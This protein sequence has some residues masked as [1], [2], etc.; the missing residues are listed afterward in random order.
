MIKIH[1]VKPKNF[2]PG[3]HVSICSLEFDG[4]FLLL[5]RAI[6][7]EANTWCLPGGKIDGNETP[8]Q[9]MLR[10]IK[11]ETGISLNENQAYR[12]GEVYISKPGIDLVLH[13]Y[14]ARLFE[15]PKI[16][17]CE[18]SSEYL[19]VSLDEALKL[20]LISGGDVVIKHYKKLAKHEL[21][22]RVAIC[23]HL[24]PIKNNQLLM[25]LR[26]NTGYEDGNYG[27]ITGHVESGES[28]VDAMIRET[29]EEAGIKLAPNQLKFVHFTHHYSYRVNTHLFYACHDWDGEFVNM[30]PH[31]CGG[32]N[33]F[34]MDKIPTNSVEYISDVIKLVQIGKSYSEKGCS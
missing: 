22:P 29:E 30:E 5:K 12:L 4:K 32:L 1:L 10:E 14:K 17:I 33:Y 3:V 31:K 8:L 15:L 34:P 25:S 9:A 18:E 11:E 19:W 23:V 13:L 28:A 20:P 6:D 21:L 2:S 24:L 7:P 26:E 16:T 27:L